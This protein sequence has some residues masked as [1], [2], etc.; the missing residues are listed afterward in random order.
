MFNITLYLLKKKIYVHGLPTNWLIETSL[1]QEKDG[2][3]QHGKNILIKVG[4]SYK[5]NEDYILN[6]IYSLTCF[7]RKYHALSRSGKTRKKN[8]FSATIWA[9]REIKISLTLRVLEFT[10]FEYADGK[11]ITKWGQFQSKSDLIR[12]NVGP[13]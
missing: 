6:H 12:V 13:S 5:H 9:N 8:N 1:Q 10:G 4:T 3:L 2:R 7:F 11:L